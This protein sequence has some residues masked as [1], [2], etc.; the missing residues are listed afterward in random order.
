MEGYS[1][2]AKVTMVIHF[3]ATEEG[4]EP[5]DL[6][7]FYME[8]FREGQREITGIADFIF[9][10]SIDQHEDGNEPR[11]V[12]TWS[13]E[14]DCW[15]SPAHRVAWEWFDVTEW[16]AW[17]GSP[18]EGHPCVEC[19]HAVTLRGYQDQENPTH[20]MHECHVILAGG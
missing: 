19:G 17:D 20:Q 4:D 18:V 14:G 3:N 13:D 12:L 5:D 11:M 15:F 2:S 9:E 10:E 8:K 16:P 6:L 1:H 7:S